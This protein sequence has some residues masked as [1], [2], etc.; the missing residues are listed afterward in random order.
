LSQG[1]DVA[2]CSDAGTPGI[3]DPG[4]VL[5]NEAI[6]Q[7]ITVVPI[8]GASAVI[9]ALC[10]SGLP[11][12]AFTF[13]AFLPAKAAQRRALLKSLEPETRTIVFYESPNRLRAALTDIRTILGNRRIAV[14]R[15]LTKL[16]E[17]IL[18]GTIDQ[19]LDLLG[20]RTPK[21]EITLVIA[22]REGAC[23]AYS[24]DDIRGRLEELACSTDLTSRGRVDQVVQETGLS[25]RRVY[26]IAVEIVN[27][28]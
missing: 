12:H 5:V 1:F 8:P 10:A 15:E 21:G 25:R 14:A 28:N 24:D 11:M 18:R 3:S 13:H 27:G 19:V 22:G 2:Y 26:R 23:P 20:D 17:E 6:A 9:A 4:Y 16:Y 7:G